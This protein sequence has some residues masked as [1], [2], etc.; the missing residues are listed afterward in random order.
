MPHNAAFHQ[1]LH[2]LSR[3]ATEIFIKIQKYLPCDPLKFKMN[4]FMLILYQCVQVNPSEFKGLQC[5]CISQCDPTYK[6]H[7]SNRSGQQPLNFI[8]ERIY[9]H[10]NNASI[11][12]SLELQSYYTLVQISEQIGPILKRQLCILKELTP[13][14]S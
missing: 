12:T 14:Y 11:M 4:K 10:C 8:T 1:G 3:I 2:C 5:Q 13:R 7:V 6:R 9:L